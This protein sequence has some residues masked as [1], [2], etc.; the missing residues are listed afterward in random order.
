MNWSKNSMDAENTD[1]SLSKFNAARYWDYLLG[2]HYNFEVDRAA[3]DM[4]M[5][6]APDTRLGAL[7]NRAFLRRSVRFLAQQGIDQFIDLG[8]GIPT[9]GNVHAIASKVNPDAHTVYVDRDA[10][11]VVHSRSILQDVPNTAVIEENFL[12]LE[13]L[14]KRDELTR[15]IDLNKPVGILMVSVLHFV[16][17][18]AQA[19]R[20]LQTILS[21]ISSGSY[22]VISHYSLENAPQSSIDQILRLANYSS[23]AS[24]SRS[25]LEIEYLFE[26][27]KLIDPGVVCVPAWQPEADD[28]LLVQEP[29]RALSYCG[30]GVKE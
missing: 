21:S 12:N 17:N 27:F 24:K 20:L 28:E 19:Q 10:V 25:R 2:G 5:K 11:A 29:E 16:S 4:I 14:F 23:N 22:L 26:G 1:L 7:A 15:L 9:V 13:E 3:G 6:V 8:S 30:V 18:D